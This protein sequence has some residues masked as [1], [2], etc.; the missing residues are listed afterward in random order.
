M[1]LTERQISKIATRINLSPN[2]LIVMIDVSE[3]K[4]ISELE[5]L[6]NIYCV[7]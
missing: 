4:N 1:K 3:E 7:N 5:E 2:K 6:Y